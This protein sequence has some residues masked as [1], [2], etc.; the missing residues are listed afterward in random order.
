MAEVK[1]NAYTRVLNRRANRLGVSIGLAERSPSTK[2]LYL[3]AAEKAAIRLGTTP[4]AVLRDD[5]Q[6]LENSSYPTAKCLTP[7]DFEDLL[8]GLQQ[9]NLG[10]ETLL[11]P[12]GIKLIEKPDP[13]WAEQLAHLATCDPCRILLVACLPNAARQ[14]AFEEYVGKVFEPSVAK[15]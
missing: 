6:R 13:A 9:R 3:V 10:I 15:V 4:E 14:K 5:L 1:S 8:E 7:D 2:P 12:E 11:K